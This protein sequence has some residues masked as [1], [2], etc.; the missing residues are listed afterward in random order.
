[1]PGRQV[2]DPSVGTTIRWCQL[3][4][5]HY[6]RLAYFYR[7][8]AKAAWY[9]QQSSYHELRRQKC[10]EFWFGRIESDQSDLG[11][12]WRS[13]D[14]LLGRGRLTANSAIDVESF[15][16]SLLRRPLRCSPAPAAHLHRYFVMRDP[17]RRFGPFYQWTPMT[18]STPFVDFR[19]NFRQPIRYR[20][21]SS[22]KSLM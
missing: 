1:M 5:C 11:K 15:N 2:S 6:Q 8:D 17:T 19:T 4:C 20:R 12:L 13:V 10:A 14:V 9:D 3:S 22:R 16:V 18:S 21:Q 7:R